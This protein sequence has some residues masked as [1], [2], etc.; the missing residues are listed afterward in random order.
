[1][2]HSSFMYLMGPDGKFRALFRPGM[3]AQELADAIHA[4]MSTS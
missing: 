4:Q 2:D 3:S 1:M